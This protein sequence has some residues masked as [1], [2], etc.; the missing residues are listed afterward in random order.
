[1]SL[2][3]DIGGGTTDISFFT[4]EN[5]KPQVYTFFSIDKGLNYLTD[6]DRADKKRPDS[7]ANNESEIL[8]EKKKDFNISINGICH[9]LLIILKKEFKRQVHLPEHRLTDALKMRPIIYTGG[10]STFECMRAPHGGFQDVIHISDKDWHKESVVNINRIKMLNL[11]PILS[12]AYGLSI[13]V[14]DDYIQTKPF[15]DIFKHLR[16]IEP[17]NGKNKDTTNFG[18]AYGGFSYADDWDAW[19]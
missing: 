8:S 4:I 17:E 19:K 5:N 3:V 11:C 9:K 18:Q 6:A 7:N 13:S 15:I 16:G 14:V 2:M 1:M 10:G 12:T